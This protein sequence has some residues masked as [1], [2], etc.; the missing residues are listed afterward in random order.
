MSARIPRLQMADLR[1]DLA[2]YLADTKVKR[3]GYL[4]EYFQCTA[5]NPD[6]LLAF[7]AFTDALGKA[8]PKNLGEIVALSVAA[9]ME[10]AYERNQHEQLCVKLGFPREWIAAVNAC[11]PDRATRLSPAEAAVQRY[12]LAAVVRRGMSV[13]DEFDALLDHLTPAEAM[14]VTMLTG[15]YIGHALTTNTL[16]LAPPVPSIFE[17]EPR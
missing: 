17:P 2:A 13:A 6:A 12:T 9:L 16:G 7:M 10:N 8:L 3:L 14:A 11:A 5:H 4:G 1:P 15:R